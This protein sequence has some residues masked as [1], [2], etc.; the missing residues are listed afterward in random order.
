[1]VQGPDDEDVQIYALP[2]LGDTRYIC[3][4]KTLF[5]QWGVQYLSEHPTIDEIV[6][7]AQRMTG[8]NPVTGEDN[9]GV[10]WRGTDASDTVV[11]IAEALGGTWGSGNRFSEL[12]YNFNSEAFVQAAEILK[13]LIPYAPQ[14]VMS[15]AG[16]EK[17]GT[18]ENDVAIN[19]RTMPGVLM[20]I[21]ELGNADRY[22]I[23]YL[24]VNPDTGTGGLFAGSPFAIGSTSQV[25]DLAWEFIKYSSGEFFQSYLW[26][27]CGEV[28][29]INA[30]MEFEGIKGDEQYG[31]MLDSMR[32]LWTPRYPY[33]AANPRG[34]LVAAIES[35]VNGTLDA[36]TALDQAQADC[37]VWTSEQ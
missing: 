13:A 17:F 7:K 24:F 31:K 10:F 9:Y 35:I 25:K 26:T 15:N 2:V 34:V 5:D 20:D 30:A 4:D 23:A 33:R 28:P 27:E 11:N 6:E 8:K 36:K 37:E 1:M 32:Y 3:Y 12:H 16:G 22:E 14:G 18:N 29:C 19:L 21:K